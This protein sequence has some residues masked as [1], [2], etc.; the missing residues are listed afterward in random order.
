MKFHRSLICRISFVYAVLVIASLAALVFL[1]REDSPSQSIADLQDQ[2][3]GEALLA[4]SALE[5][6]LANPAYS[7]D[8][9]SLQEV[10]KT[11]DRW[12]DSRVTVISR[13]GEPL[14]SSHWDNVVSG[15]QGSSNY[16]FQSDR[17]LFRARQ[18]NVAS[19]LKHTFHA[20]Y[21]QVL[22]TGAPIVIDGNVVGVL[23]LE[24]PVP[25]PSLGVGAVTLL[26]GDLGGWR[27]GHWA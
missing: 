26:V 7:P 11:L 14:S 27:W 19:S 1:L 12:T 10:A 3:E 15:R 9:E 25:E 8:L 4:A 24:T 23:M 16:D 17:Y 13:T 21:S 22:Y 5:P 6:Y 20:D 18:G 2:K